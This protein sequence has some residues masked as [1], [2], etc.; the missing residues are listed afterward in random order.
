M[1]IWPQGGKRMVPV[2][3]GC[4]KFEGW[5]RWIWKV[6][7]GL[8]V[9]ETALTADGQPGSSETSFDLFLCI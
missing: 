9:I 6:C 4:W 5:K 8:A 1:G 7:L 2:G 3:D